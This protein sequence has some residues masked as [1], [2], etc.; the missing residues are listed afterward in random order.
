MTI[1]DHIRDEKIQYNINRDYC[2][3][4]EITA[5]KSSQIKFS[6]VKNK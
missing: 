6:E 4:I 5:I 1:N 3:G 2:N